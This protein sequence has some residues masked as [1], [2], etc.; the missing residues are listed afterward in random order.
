MSTNRLGRGLG[1]L[2]QEH[3]IESIESFEQVKEGEVVQQLDVKTLR[4]NPY[5]PRKYF[6]ETKIN[7]LALSIKEHGVFQPIIVKKDIKG[8]IIIAGERRFRAAQKA[9]LQTIPAIVREFNDHLMMEYALIENLQREDLT[10]IEEAEAYKMLMQKLDLTQERLAERIGKSRAY[11]ANT[12]RLLQLPRVVQDDIENNIIS[13]GHGKVL[14]GLKD[15]DLI[16][17]FANVIKEK[18]ISVRELEDLIKDASINQPEIEKKVTK[19]LNP[20]LDYVK[21]NLESYFGTKVKIKEKQ[22]KGQIIINYNDLDNLNHLLEI[23]G[24]EL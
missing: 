2:F 7:E 16:I 12:M 15:E 5:Q 22:G 11:I 10:A 9:N 14:A 3:D 18:Q 20:H 24:I 23:M 4:P 21:T 1:A 6:D 19:V 8:Y 13:V 17:K